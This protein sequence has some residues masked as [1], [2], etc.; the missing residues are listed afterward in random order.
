MRRALEA[1]LKLDLTVQFTDVWRDA[2]V[3]V[4]LHNRKAATDLQRGLR[5]AEQL[6]NTNALGLVIHGDPGSGKTHLVREGRMALERGGG[7]F[8]QLDINR[9]DDFTTAALLSFLFSLTEGTGE[10]GQQIQQLLLKLL[11]QTD[12]TEE[13]KWNIKDNN[14]NPKAVEAAVAA[15]H[16]A[17]GYL[18][19]AARDVVRA[20]CLLSSRHPDHLGIAEDWLSCRTEST[21]GKRT[22][23]GIHPTARQPREVLLA[24]TKVVALVGPILFCI[25]QIDEMVRKAELNTFGDSSEKDLDGRLSNLAA[26]LMDFI[27][28]SRRTLVVVSCLHGSWSRLEKATLTSVP[29]RFWTP[30]ALDQQLTGDAARA[31]I[32]RHVDARMEEVDFKPPWLGWPVAQ[33]VFEE[34]HSTPR[35]VLRCVQD[36]AKLCLDQD[37]FF[38]LDS[39]EPRKSDDPIQPTASISDR[40]EQILHDVDVTRAMSPEHE[41]AELPQLLVAGLR[42]YALETGT[43]V[44]VHPLR[45]TNDNGIHVIVRENGR[46]WCLRGVSNGRG[47]GFKARL[48][49][50]LEQSGAEKDSGTAAIALRTRSWA[51][52]AKG[53]RN[54]TELQK[55]GLNVVD[56]DPAELRVCA[57]LR[58]LETERHH[59]YDAWLRSS[60]PMSR[61]ALIRNIFEEQGGEPP[62]EDPDQLPLPKSSPVPLGYFADGTTA[63]VDLEQLRKHVAVFAGSG[64][65]KTVVLRRLIE[66]CALQGV[67][68]IVLDPNND[69]A[70]LGVPWPN[71]PAAWGPGDDDKAKRYFAG[72]EVIVWTPRVA[73]GRPVSFQPLPDFGAVIDDED[74]FNHALDSAVAALAP[75]ARVAGNTDKHEQ[76]RAVIRLGLM[77]Y[78]R[79]C[80]E[81]LEG[82]LQLLADFPSDVVNLSKATDLA[83]TISET[84]RAS[85]INDPLF[86]GAGAPID[87]GELLKPSDGRQARIS[88]VS[89]IGLPDAVQRQGFVNQL[90]MALFAWIKRNPAGDRPLGGLFVIDEAQTFAPSGTMTPCTGSTL[91]LA[92]Q[93]RKYGLGMVFATQAPRGIHNQVVGN[94]AT[95][96][97]GFLNA[98]TQVAAV[99]EMVDAKQAKDLEV[100]GL[101]AGDFYLRTEGRPYQRVTTPMCLSHH[102]K[103]ALTPEEVV[104]LSREGDGA[105]D[106][107]TA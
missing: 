40:F 12:L 18:D 30:R 97:V 17:F 86:G 31:I 96:L 87:P 13:F 78:A 57:A 22:Q 98:P 21:D 93:A 36:H 61:T 8:V 6:R 100:S 102:P 95:Q 37:D 84:L 32:A 99:K 10:R 20:L 82:F 104:R 19:G 60:R 46:R 67:S 51:L 69:L 42:A 45:K 68:S 53:Q 105:S 28:Q 26:G 49:W 48:T 24:L 14:P 52:T 89:L 101:S 80:G 41:D 39:L 34:Q 92:S 16:A 94:C 56:L 23:W 75:R 71:P 58:Q 7:L 62:P 27:E 66:E 5:D 1:L 83:H 9:S 79:H 88:V 3:N 81:G 43:A 90:Q 91:A 85:Q 107:P 25:D 2:D 50:L 103:S 35:V 47:I 76:G 4:D 72:A 65:G 74:E 33:K 63:S 29:G 73:K 54:L 11:D 70:R 38:P 64:S 106:D 59:G 55:R 77:H 44:N 15:V